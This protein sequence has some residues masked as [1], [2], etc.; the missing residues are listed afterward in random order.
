MVG[1]LDNVSQCTKAGFSYYKGAILID[2]DYQ[3]FEVVDARKLRTIVGL[4]LDRL[5]DLLVGNPRWQ[6]ELLFGSTPTTSSL[7]EV[8]RLIFASF[9]KDKYVWEEM[10]DFEEFRERVAGATSMEAIFG[11]FQEFHQA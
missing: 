11:A 6:V 4:N 1:S 3:K 9:K 7:D 8:K 10:T 5:F 2:S